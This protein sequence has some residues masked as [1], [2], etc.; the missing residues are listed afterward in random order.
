MTGTWRWPLF[1]IYC[2]G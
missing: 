2:R 1:S